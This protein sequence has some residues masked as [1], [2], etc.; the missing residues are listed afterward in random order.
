MH[1]EK[2]IIHPERFPTTEHYPYNLPLLQRTDEVVFSTP[3]TFFVGENGTGKSTLLRAICRKS[4]I[5]IWKG[6][7]RVRYEHN[8][9]EE[10]LHRA[11]ELE[12]SNG[13]VTGSFFGSEM[14]RDFTR[15]LDEWAIDD[16]GLLDFFG[17]KSLVTQSHGQSILAYFSSR[18]QIK[19]LYFMDE[20]ETAL[21]P[22]SQLAL[23]QILKRMSDARHAQFVIAT[24]SPILMSCPG[25]TILCFDSIPI[26]P[27]TYE[28]TEHYQ[29]Y[30]SFLEDRSRFMDNL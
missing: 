22:R 2:V 21:S 25:A 1:L 12:W 5:H 20:P 3:V 27:I 16:R 13:R 9:Y 14:F 4:G 10:T 6:I 24:H 19:G 29:V 17:G 11:L 23:L 18:Y 26:K 8:P 7:E 28:D 15:L 30:K